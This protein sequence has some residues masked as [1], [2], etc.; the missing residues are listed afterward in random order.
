[1]PSTSLRLRELTLSS[2]DVLTGLVF[3]ISLY[4]REPDT[5]THW[6]G[7][8]LAAGGPGVGAGLAGGGRNACRDGSPRGRT[9]P[10]AAEE[11]RR[12]FLD[13]EIKYFQ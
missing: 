4:E 10:E 11:R 13:K 8:A 3:V 12:I 6:C 1:M 5:S 2:S 7:G 9:R